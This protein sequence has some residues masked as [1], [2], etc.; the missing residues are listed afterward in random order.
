MKSLIVACLLVLAVLA[1]AQSNHPCARLL[2][3]NTKWDIIGFFNDFHDGLDEVHTNQ[4]AES[5]SVQDYT[6]AISDVFS[7]FTENANFTILPGRFANGTYKPQLNA[8]GRSSV[9]GA[10]VYLIRPINGGE[11]RLTGRDKVTC[12]DD[13]RFRLVRNA[14]A[15]TQPINGTIFLGEMNIIPARYEVEI[16]ANEDGTYSIDKLVYDQRGLYK[17]ESITE[18]WSNIQVARRYA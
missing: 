6:V 17:V 2:S 10:M 14:A 13:N 3:W 16:V 8:I 4:Y 7:V 15:L 9:I 5:W 18:P 1:S 12:I 11:L